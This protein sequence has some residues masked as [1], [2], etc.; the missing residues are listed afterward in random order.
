MKIKQV[1]HNDFPTLYIVST[2]I[3]NLD[4]FTFRAV[5]T[6][7]KVDLILCE[8][9]R[10]TSKLL[11]HFDIKNTLMSYQKFSEVEK[12]NLIQD[13]LSK[14]LNIALVS[15]AGTP[16]LS[17]PGSILVT[18]LLNLDVNV[19]SIP[20]A[21]ALLSA[22]VV[23]GLYQ[24]QFTFIGFLPRKKSLQI[25]TLK[26]FKKNKN[27]FLLYESPNRVLETLKLIE[28]I[29]GDRLVTV[30]REITK[31]HETH[32]HGLLSEFTSEILDH[33]GEYVLIIDGAKEEVNIE[34]PLTLYQSFIED[35]MDEKEAIK[36]T[37]KSLNVHKSVI[38]K[39]IKIK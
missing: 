16:L 28:S 17:D 14:G 25:E 31:L 9:T 35:G 7:K 4:D 20:G 23:S 26:A 33:R 24:S 1:F 37:A 10:V 36:E 12:L 8:D 22:L 27:P 34:D 18:S 5:E 3:G 32:Y 6:L 30:L 21:S 11:N 13:K 38:Y 2:P 29:L 39:L 19:V 15:D